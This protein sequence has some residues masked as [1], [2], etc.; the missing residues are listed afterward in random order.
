[1][2]SIQDLIGSLPKDNS[3]RMGIV[4]GRRLAADDRERR[5]TY[6]PTEQDLGA[7]RAGR[8]KQKVLCSSWGRER[9][10]NRL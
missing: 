8:D 1:M 5:S 10:E 2:M 3:Q 7:A 9:V 6:F 4:P